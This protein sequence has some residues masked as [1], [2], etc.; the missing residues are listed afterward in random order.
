MT[1]FDVVLGTVISE[2]VVKNLTDGTEKRKDDSGNSMATVLLRW[3]W[4]WC[5]NV[6]PCIL[7]SVHFGKWCVLWVLL[8]WWQFRHTPAQQGKCRVTMVI[9]PFQLWSM[10]K[11][12]TH[13]FSPTSARGLDFPTYLPLHGFPVPHHYYEGCMCPEDAVAVGVAQ[14]SGGDLEDSSAYNPSTLLPGQ[15]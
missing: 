9:W 13:L 4:F 8:P 7:L 11:L 2:R 15:F 14:V 12:S 1:V 5:K 6:E 3:P 10:E